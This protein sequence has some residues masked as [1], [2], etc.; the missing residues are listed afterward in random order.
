MEE[1]NQMEEGMLTTVSGGTDQE[2]RELKAFI[3]RHDPEF[4]VYNHSD[5]F[6]WLYKE[7]GISFRSVGDGLTGNR[8][9]LSDGTSISHEQLMEMPKERFPEEES[10]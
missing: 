6:R 4:R 7:S 8:Y 3:R 9:V 5:I 2:D 10:L 1:K